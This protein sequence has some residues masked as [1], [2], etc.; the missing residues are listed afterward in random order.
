ML[1]I[2]RCIGS[3]RSKEETWPLPETAK[4]NEQGGSAMGRRKLEVESVGEAYLALLADR[5]VEYLFANSGTDFAPIIE[6][7]CKPGAS[8]PVP[9]TVPHENV[10]VSMAHGYYM[11]SG[12]PQAVM[13]H[14]SVGT[15]NG[16]CAIMNAA[17]AQVPILFTAGRTPILEAGHPGARDVPIHWPQEMFDQAGMVREMVKWEYELRSGDQV[18]TVVD[19]AL[20]LSMTEPRGPIYLTL[21][22]EVLGEKLP[23]LEFD[24]PGRRRTP[25]A[26]HPDP[27]AIAEAAEMIAAAKNPLIITSSAGRDAATVDAL[28]AFADRFAIPVTQKWTRLYNLPTDHPMHLGYEPGPFLED[29]DVILVLDADVPWVPSYQEP[30]PDC[31]VIHMG[32]DPLFSRYP[33]RGHRCDLAVTGVLRAAIP[34]LAEAL[35]G[36]EPRMVSAIAARRERVAATR[37]AQRSR[38]AAAIDGAASRAPI[39][40]TWVSHCLDQVKAD[41]TIILKE[42]PLPMEPLTLGQPHTFFHG[43]AAGGLGWALGAA[44]G[45]KLA[46]PDQLVVAAIG[47]GS[48]MFSCPVSAHSVSRQY[49]LPFLTIILNNGMWGS[50]R[51]SARSMYPDGHAARS[52]DEPLVAL[53]GTPYLEKV[54]E[55]SGGYGVRVERPEDLEGALAEAVRVVTT[56]RRQ[57]VVNVITQ[58]PEGSFAGTAARSA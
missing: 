34:A 42:G 51:Q 58:G 15:A 17:R 6:P 44:L 29:A 28:S 52:N 30:R 48:Y 36:H 55:A 16:V 56:E 41:D 54:V 26:P 50:V 40:P 11:V 47:D 21:P 4:H 19:R 22:R 7:M 24:S 37:D 5:G 45:A 39:Q 43:H 18:E 46:R 10:A 8:F 27:A 2:A 9:I 12:R 38:W 33:I 3:W 35:A 23:S 53:D 32:A 14:V 1:T 49:D 31:A 20:N 13:L 25:S 57:A